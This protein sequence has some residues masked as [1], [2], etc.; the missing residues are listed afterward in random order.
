MRDFVGCL[1]N[2][3]AMVAE[4]TCSVNTS[5]S[6][7]AE[8]TVQDAITCF[9]R[10][11]LSSGKELFTQVVWS[12]NQVGGAFLSITVQY[13]ISP[14]K[15][16]AYLVRK[17]K[18]RRSF[19]AGDTA[20]SLHWDTSAAA[21]ESGPEPSKAFYLAIVAD[22]EFALLLGDMCGRFIEH[23]G[24]THPI[25]AFSMVSRREQVSPREQVPGETL[26]STKAALVDGG[27]EHEIMIRCKGDE[28]NAKESELYVE[29]DKKEVVSVRRLRWNFRGN[30]A[31]F[32]D[33]STVDVMWDVHGWWFCESS[34]CAMFTFRR[35]SAMESRLWLD[36][37]LEQGFSAFSLLIHVFKN[38]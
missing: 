28:L 38:Q 17:K 22:S 27:K 6:A 14:S 24:A 23:F 16:H 21:Y 4:A 30:Q 18:G 29:V 10:T 5:A 34:R 19:A 15:P 35:R 33:G 32:V 12:A 25:A 13:G 9:Y 8:P 7:M 37:D 3:A 36:G 26:Y 11:V 31:I 2:Q 1:A 20:I